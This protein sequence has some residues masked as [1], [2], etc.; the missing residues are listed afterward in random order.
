MP[1]PTAAFGTRLK[2]IREAKGLTQV[3][4]AEKLGV[5]QDRISRLERGA[6]EPGWTNVCRIADALGVS[7]QEFRSSG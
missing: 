7:V 2:A 1:D 3:Q 6:V 4:L 5:Q